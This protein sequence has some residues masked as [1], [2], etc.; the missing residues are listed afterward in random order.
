[1]RVE[2]K[3][4]L[5]REWMRVEFKFKLSREWMRVE[6]KFKLSREWMA[7]ATAGSTCGDGHVTHAADGERKERARGESERREREERAR[8]ESDPEER[9]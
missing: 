3:F 1:M 9:A 6:F 5:S 8:G 4:K 7:P 2:F